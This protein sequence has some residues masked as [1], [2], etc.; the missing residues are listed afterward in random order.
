MHIF[1]ILQSVHSTKNIQKQDIHPSEGS[2][3]IMFRSTSPHSVSQGTLGPWGVTGGCQSQISDS[4]SVQGP[5]HSQRP[6]QGVS[7][8]HSHKGA[9]PSRCV[10]KSDFCNKIKKIRLRF[11]WIREKAR[12]GGT[13]VSCDIWSKVLSSYDAEFCLVLRA[14][15]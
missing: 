9:H 12:L 1:F 10:G 11:I 6:S 3:T 7:S 15:I 13:H 14:R 4:Q 5:Q 8:F 2:E